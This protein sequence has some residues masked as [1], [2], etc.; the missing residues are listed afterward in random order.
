MG[1]S[2]IA[3]SC[4]LAPASPFVEA[5]APV[6]SGR[7]TDPGQAPTKYS[8][9]MLLNGNMDDVTEDLCAKSAAL[10]VRQAHVD[11]AQAADVVAQARRFLEL[12]VP[13]RL[14]HL[15]F[16]LA[17]ELDAL[18]RRHGLVAGAL[19]GGL[20]QRRPHTGGIG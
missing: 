12:Q 20:R 9:F 17:D 18:L 13:R 2:A 3:A 14:L 19:V 15:H 10:H 11:L 6:F 8:A 16:H 5:I 7:N 1:T 4:L